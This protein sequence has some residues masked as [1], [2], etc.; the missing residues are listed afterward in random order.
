ML[1]TPGKRSNA[2]PGVA[3]SP[4]SRAIFSPHALLSELQLLLR[5][6][7]PVRFRACAR[8]PRCADAGPELPGASTAPA[9]RAAS[10]WLEP[11]R[12]HQR[13]LRLELSQDFRDYRLDCTVCVHA[14]APP[15]L[16]FWPQQ[17][18]CAKPDPSSCSPPSPVPV[19]YACVRPPPV[20]VDTL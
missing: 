20:I 18:S 9:A 15:E 16:V 13:S 5:R 14:R 19:C 4:Q 1:T 11:Q 6:C 12:L 3:S 17:M 8:H 2:R 10:A 7:G